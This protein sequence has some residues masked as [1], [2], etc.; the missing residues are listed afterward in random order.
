MSGASALGGPEDELAV[1]SRPR[2][3]R[4]RPPARSAAAART[5][6]RS[7]AR[8]NEIRKVVS[9]RA[10]VTGPA[11]RSERYPSPPWPVSTIAL[12]GVSRPAPSALRAASETVIVYSVSGAQCPT[13]ATVSTRPA[14]SHCEVDRRVGRD[15]ERGRDGGGLHR[16]GEGDR[17]RV[18]EGMAGPDDIEQLGRDRLGLGLRNGDARRRRRLA[19]TTSPITALGGDAGDDPGP[20]P[21][22]SQQ[23]RGRPG[24]GRAGRAGPRRAFAIAG[25]PLRRVEGRPGS[26]APAP[27]RRTA[28][29]ARPPATGRRVTPALA[30]QGDLPEAAAM[31]ARPGRPSAAPDSRGSGGRSAARPGRGR[32]TR[33]ADASGPAARYRPKVSR[34]RPR[35]SSDVS[36]TEH[37]G[38]RPPVARTSSSTDPRPAA[39]S[40]ATIRSTRSQHG[41][42]RPPGDR[43]A[44]PRPDARSLAACGRGGRGDADEVEVDRAAPGCRPR[45]APPGPPR[46]GRRGS[47]R[48]PGRPGARARDGAPGPVRGPTPP[49]SGPR[50]GHPPRRRRSRPR[51]R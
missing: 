3:R 48:R 8:S 30:G 31:Q 21:A 46:A 18:L 23:R 14:V 45:S 5:A 39:T 13:G 38:A 25:P 49:S 42:D 37:R 19:T 26:L 15:P 2:R 34:T 40:R 36:A 22:L 29:A 43:L 17:E 32:P 44:G 51:G 16:R 28:L 47:L 41:Q 50:S 35:T 20:H 6:A 12:T 33:A 7:T 1:R 11:H 10:R 4:R 9:R 27:G 24:T